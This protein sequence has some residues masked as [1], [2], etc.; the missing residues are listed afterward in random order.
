MLTPILGLVAGL[1]AILYARLSYGNSPLLA[2]APSFLRRKRDRLWLIGWI[3]IG[4]TLM[5]GE[6]A[7]ESERLRGEP[8]RVTADTPVPGLVGAGIGAAAGGGRGAAAG[9]LAGMGAAYIFAMFQ[10]ERWEIAN[11]PPDR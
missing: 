9:G 1:L 4:L 5:A 10:A 8:H 3:V 2:A 11:Y 7:L 6:R